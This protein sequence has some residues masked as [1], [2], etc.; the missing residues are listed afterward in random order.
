MLIAVE[1]TGKSQLKLGQGN[2]GD[3][4][5]LSHFSLLRNP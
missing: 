1:G 2:K 4:A 3:A 5:L